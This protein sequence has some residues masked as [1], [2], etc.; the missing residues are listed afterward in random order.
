[1]I[2]DPHLRDAQAHEELLQI[3]RLRPEV[4]VAHERG[5]RHLSERASSTGQPPARTQPDSTLA[6]SGSFGL[7]LVRAL[8]LLQAA[9]DQIWSLSCSNSIPARREEIED[10]D[11]RAAQRK[12]MALEGEIEDSM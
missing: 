9:G 1:M 8:A 3:A 11:P 2:H 6:T 7:W 10:A 12:S 4:E 5:E